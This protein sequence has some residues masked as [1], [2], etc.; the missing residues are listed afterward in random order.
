MVKELGLD[1]K[2]MIKYICID[3]PIVQVF[4]QQ[5]N[6]KRYADGANNAVD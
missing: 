2:A 3:N 1:P 4:K 6:M 5:E